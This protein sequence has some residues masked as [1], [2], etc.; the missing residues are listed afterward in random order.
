MSVCKRGRTIEQRSRA[1]Y[2]EWSVFLTRKT[3]KGRVA[4]ERESVPKPYS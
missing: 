4:A 1:N 3:E 2:T